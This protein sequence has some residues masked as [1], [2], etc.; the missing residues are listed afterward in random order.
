MLASG[1]ASEVRTH[2][3]VGLAL[4]RPELPVVVVYTMLEGNTLSCTYSVGF[5]RP[6]EQQLHRA[7][8]TTETVNPE[9]YINDRACACRDPGKA[10]CRVVIERTKKL[11]FKRL[12]AHK[13]K[14]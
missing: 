13:S 4:S 2:D 5:H 8:L 11:A 12:S 1:N 3:G 10:C 6:C 14:A 7:S 9:V